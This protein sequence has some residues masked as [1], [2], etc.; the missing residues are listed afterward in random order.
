[1]FEFLFKYPPAIFAKGKLTLLSPWPVWLMAVLFVLAAGALYWQMRRRRSVLSRLRSTLIW[2]IQTVLIA[3]LLFML[4]HPA[5]S[6]ARLRPQQNVI[7][8]L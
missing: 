7:A 6:V 4:W 1:M 8:V 5:I 3:I 2:L